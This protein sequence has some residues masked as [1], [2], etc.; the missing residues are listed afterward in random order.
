MHVMMINDMIID[1]LIV[2]KVRI[3]MNTSERITEKEMTYNNEENF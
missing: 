1:K 2:E 3:L